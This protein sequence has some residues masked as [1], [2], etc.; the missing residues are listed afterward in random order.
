MAAQI[1]NGFELAKE[2]RAQLAKEVE[3]LKQQGIEPALAVIL[4]GDHP[5]SQSY[6]KS[7]AKK[8]VKKLAFVRFY[9]LSQT[10]YLRS[11]C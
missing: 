11:F 9:L 6:V 2:K 1:I 5:A 8:H 10:T 3:Q 7:E 4:V